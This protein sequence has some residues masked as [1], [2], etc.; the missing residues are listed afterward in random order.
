[1]WDFDA[2]SLPG[3]GSEEVYEPDV[4]EPHNNQTGRYVTPFKAQ[5][6]PNTTVEPHFTI[7]NMK[8]ASVQL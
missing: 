8:R 1:M 2:A 5:W 6:S 4:I 7:G 3:A